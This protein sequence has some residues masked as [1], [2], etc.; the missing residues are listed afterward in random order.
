M[1]ISNEPEERGKREKTSTKFVHS[2]ASVKLCEKETKGA[3]L[4]Q[5]DTKGA[6]RS[7]MKPMGV[8]GSH[9]KHTVVKDRQME[10]Y[11]DI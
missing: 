2:C 4:S 5:K 1:R 8:I 9:R 3:E 6:N 10:Q 11:G 7:Q